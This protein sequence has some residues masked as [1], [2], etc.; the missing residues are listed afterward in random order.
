M[1]RNYVCWEFW[2]G[3]AWATIRQWLGAMRCELSDGNG[4]C[5][6]NWY[7]EMF[8]SDESWNPLNAG[9]EGLHTRNIQVRPSGGSWYMFD[10]DLGFSGAWVEQG[11]YW[12]TRVLSWHNF[13]V[14]C[15]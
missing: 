10:A 5:Q 7:N 8:S 13:L 3:S 11:P 1:L 9:G 12:L 6:F 4:N 14:Y 15:C 2:T